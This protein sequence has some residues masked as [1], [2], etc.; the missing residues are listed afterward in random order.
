MSG[1]LLFRS[2]VAGGQ[3]TCGLTATGAA[4]CWGLGSALGDSSFNNQS[5]PVAV[6]G[7]LTFRSL[8]AG[9]GEIFEEHTCGLTADGSAY[10]WGYNGFG[11]LG[12]G[13][14]TTRTAPVAVAPLSSLR[15]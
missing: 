4:Y 6:V 12:D 15:A 10:C 5:T 14:T 2:I 8:V 13:T 9:G 7:G 1:G 3:H 11:E